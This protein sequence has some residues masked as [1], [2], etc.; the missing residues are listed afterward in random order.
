MS[1]MCQVSHT[2]TNMSQPPQPLFTAAPVSILQ[3][4]IRIAMLVAAF[5]N[6][7]DPT[8]DFDRYLA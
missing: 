2:L 1:E 4:P 8:F 7:I 3:H 5:E 6:I